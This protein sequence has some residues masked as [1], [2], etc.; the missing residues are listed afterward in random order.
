MDGYFGNNAFNQL[1][2]LSSCPSPEILRD[3][4]L[5]PDSPNGL[6]NQAKRIPVSDLLLSPCS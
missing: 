1:V 4:V 3:F 2:C 6:G 5:L